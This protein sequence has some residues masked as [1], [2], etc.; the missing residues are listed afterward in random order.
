M[1]ATG[2][3]P[4]WIIMKPI[5]GNIKVYMCIKAELHQRLVKCCA[6]WIRIADWNVEREC[7]ACL[8]LCM[9]LYNNPRYNPMSQKKCKTI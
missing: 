4:I 6:C 9:Y 3:T 8:P 1:I 5:V 2:N 7:K